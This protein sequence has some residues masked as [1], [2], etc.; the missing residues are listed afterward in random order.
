MPAPEAEKPAVFGN[1]SLLRV[2]A[3]L[4]DGTGYPLRYRA[5]ILPDGITVGTEKNCQW[6]LFALRLDPAKPRSYFLLAPWAN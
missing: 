3:F 6:N 5:P 1:I 4:A 2:V